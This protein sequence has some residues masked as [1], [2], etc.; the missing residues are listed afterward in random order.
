MKVILLKDI[1]G[2]GR[3][4]DVKDVA[5]GFARNFLLKQ[6][7]AKAANERSM[8]GLEAVE[9][10]QKKKNEKEL[11]TAQEQAGKLDGLEIEVKEKVNDRGTLYGALDKK[12]IIDAI[13]KETNITLDQPQIKTQAPVKSL[14]DHH[15]TVEFGHG[16]EADIRVTVSSS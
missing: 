13:K 8:A 10:Q 3:K 4:G 15:I 5:D 11:H 6:G 14:G 2:T 12:K 7:L 16:I 9:L 1:K